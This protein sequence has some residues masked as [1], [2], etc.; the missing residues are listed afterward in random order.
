MHFLSCQQVQQQKDLKFL[1]E[2]QLPLSPAL[3]LSLWV[4]E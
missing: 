4:P 1:K 3:D 2:K